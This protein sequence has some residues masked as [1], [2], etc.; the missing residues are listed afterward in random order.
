MTSDSVAVCKLTW[1]HSLAV[2]MQVNMLAELYMNVGNY[3]QAT[4]LIDDTY[5]RLSTQTLPLDLMINFGICQAHMGNMGLAEVITV[6]RPPV[7]RFSFL[8]HSTSE[9]I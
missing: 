2:H 3:K 6:S 4:V 5:K 1:I 8:P 7:A 9:P